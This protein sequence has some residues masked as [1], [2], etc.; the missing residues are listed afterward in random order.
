M[1]A[2]RELPICERK[3]AFWERKVAPEQQIEWIRKI[4]DLKKRWEFTGRIGVMSK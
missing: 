3:L 1:Q 2:L 4:E